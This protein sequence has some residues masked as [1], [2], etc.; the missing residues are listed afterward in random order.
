LE[1]RSSCFIWLE[2]SI[3][4]LLHV[5]FDSYRFNDLIL[6]HFSFHLTP[7]SLWEGSQVTNSPAESSERYENLINYPFSANIQGQ[8]GMV[9][10]SGS[11]VMANQLE[12]ADKHKGQM[13]FKEEQQAEFDLQ[14]QIQ[15]QLAGIGPQLPS[16]QAQVASVPQTDPGT[17]SEADGGADAA[18]KRL[19]VSNIPFRFRDPDL[20]MMFEKFGPVMDVEIIFNERGSKASLNT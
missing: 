13:C 5:C 9:L 2:K 16:S 3:F 8:H 11:S 14:L 6:L 15:Q 4:A 20:R 17:S 18:P 10:S 19:H 12:S 1:W 7:S